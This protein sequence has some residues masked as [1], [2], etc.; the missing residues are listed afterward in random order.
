[1]WCRACIPCA[2]NKIGRHTRAP[3]RE[4][5]QADRFQQ[6]H[7]DLVSP[8]PECKGF[9]Y[10][11]TVVDRFTRWLEAFPLADATSATCARAFIRGWIS[12]FGVPEVV[13][14]DRGTSFTSRMWDD[15]SNLLGFKPHFTTAFH[16]QSNGLVERF[17]RTMKQALRARLRGSTWMDELPWVLLGLRTVPKSDSDSCA[18][19]LTYGC[20]LRLPSAL[21]SMPQGAPPTS[22]QL[23]RR[24]RQFNESVVPIPFVR[25]GLPPFHVPET[26]KDASYVFIRTD[27][28]KGPLQSPYE[29][30]FKVTKKTDKFFKVQRGSTATNVSID[31]LKPAHLLSE[32][33]LFVPRP[34]GRPKGFKS[35]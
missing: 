25:H 16:P 7:L 18:A 31:R 11:L 8:L 27:A 28:V 20:T 24:M 17:H 19:E 2:Q 6:V 10:L 14:S 30:P 3:L 26:L 33:Q 23:V 9:K 12:R 15:L 22:H 21:L 34:R 13:V 4:F 32:E 5:R 29:G 35:S 1:M